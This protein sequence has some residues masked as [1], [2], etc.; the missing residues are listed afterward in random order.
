MSAVLLIFALVIRMKIVS[1]FPQ[2][3]TRNHIEF[4]SLKL[5]SDGQI[6]EL[7]ALM[8]ESSVGR[9]LGKSIGL[10]FNLLT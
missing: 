5:D 7:R 6:K 4:D 2:V 8:P 3:W 9:R 1:N 10:R